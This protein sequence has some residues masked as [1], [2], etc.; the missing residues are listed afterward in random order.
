MP[1]RILGQRLR[2]LGILKSVRWGRA[3]MG[4][5]TR[6]LFG[7]TLLAALCVP[8]AA[9]DPHAAQESSVAGP[10]G[11]KL[12]VR[13][14]GPYDAEVPLQVVCYFKH[15]PGGDTTL[16]APVELDKRL[17]GVIASLR[18]RGEFV[19]DELE[20]ILL[21]PPEGAI[22]SNS[23][24]LIGLGDEES[25]SLER[26]ERVGRVA[27][28]EAS[29]LGAKRVA[30][31]PLI[32][33]Q[34][35]TRF[36]TGDVAN[37]VVRGVLL[38]RDTESRLQKQGLAQAYTIEEW[39]SEAGPKYFDETVSAVARAAEEAEASIAS[40]PSTPYRGGK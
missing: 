33:D 40:R 29:R 19:G 36:G 1:G 39:V 13:M 16:G 12:T 4:F 37:A 30:F 32:R 20:T 5:G 24:L 6:L 2:M 14:Q 18:D 31:A 35:S 26:M 23:L 21:S 22:K 15:K 11:L 9:D 3:A 17:G 27:L 38:A 10:G 7:A 25:L 28:R 34:G 8:A